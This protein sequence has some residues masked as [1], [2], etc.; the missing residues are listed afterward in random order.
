MGQDKK[1]L[2]KLLAFVKEIYDHP[3][4][5]EFAD[6]IREMVLADKDFQERLK[7]AVPGADPKS[8]KRIEKYLSLDFEIDE[9][10]FPDYSVIKDDDVRA[11]LHAD[12][13]EMLRYQYGTRSHKIDFAEFCRYATLQIE[14]LV[15][16]YFEKK[17][18]SDLEQ[19]IQAV[20]EGNTYEE[21]GEKKCFF[22]RNAY[23][24]TVSDI[25]L[26]LKVQA[27]QKQFSWHIW[28]INDFLRA[29]EVR[30][31]QSHRGLYLDKDL[32][33]ETEDKLKAAEA[34]NVKTNQPDNVKNEFGVPKAK[35]AIGKDILNEYNFQVWYDKQPFE[36]IISGLKRLLDMI[37]SSL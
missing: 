4:N 34:W 28:D 2:T 19:I 27:L 13:R 12:F 18:H 10:I 6:G 36:S 16:Y 35:A 31:R 14:L 11:R 33:R 8:L 24:K 32:I 21:N 29:I 30:N 3:D 1:Q 26:K 20:T 37:V 7:E 23:M 9:K 5:K 15:N 25:G 17:F 22:T